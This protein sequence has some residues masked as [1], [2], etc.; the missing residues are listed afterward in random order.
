MIGDIVILIKR[1]IKQ[2]ITCRHNYKWQWGR[3]V[4][5]NYRQCIRCEK[6]EEK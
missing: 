3:D 1:L 5:S 4:V 6:L 2:H